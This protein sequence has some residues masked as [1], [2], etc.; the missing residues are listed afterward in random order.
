MNNL[1]F[2]DNDIEIN[3]D[4]VFVLTEWGCLS[5]VLSD[6]GIDISHI[7]GKVGKHIVEDFMELMTKAGYVEKKKEE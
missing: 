5:S 6:Y 4:D 3:D 7:P 1:D 2:L